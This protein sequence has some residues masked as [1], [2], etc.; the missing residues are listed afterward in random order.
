MALLIFYIR[1]DDQTDSL[2]LNNRNSKK[3]Q[4][5]NLELIGHTNTVA[6]P[7]C[8]INED[9]GFIE[10][11]AWRI[12]E[13]VKKKL[14]N[15]TC[16]IREVT[17]IDDFNLKFGN[18]LE[19]NEN[20]LI[21][22]ETFEARCSAIDS[23]NNAKLGYTNTYMNVMNKIGETNI[24]EMN[25]NLDRPNCRRMNILLFSYDSVSRV[26]WLKRLKK[27]SEFMFN[28]MKFQLI[29]GF[30]IIGEGTPACIIP[31]LTGKIEEELPSTL[32]SDPNATYVDQ[33]YPFIWNELHHKG[34]VSM[35]N[36]D[37]PNIGTFTYRLRGMSNRTATVA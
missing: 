33:V 23:K 4:I 12:N 36:E 2:F 15:I 17:R 29:K 30:N 19:I 9:W 1:S 35:F 20:D 13:N 24:K 14:S 22:F 34:Y 27:S 18:Y 16:E 8:N 26:C 5:A 21:K 11:G 37:L 7:K 6:A 28:V 25:K 31:A 32:K 3:C 10:K